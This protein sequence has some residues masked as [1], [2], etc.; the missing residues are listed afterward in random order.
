[1]SA[2]LP[3]SGN[4]HVLISWNPLAIGERNWHDSDDR[5]MCLLHLSPWWVVPIFLCGENSTLFQLKSC[6]RRWEDLSLLHASLTLFE[7]HFLVITRKEGGMPTHDASF[8]N[9]RES[10]LLSST[11]SLDWLDPN[12][13]WKNLW[14]WRLADFFPSKKTQSNPKIMHQE[15]W[16]RSRR[17]RNRGEAL[18]PPTACMQKPISSCIET[19]SESIEKAHALLSSRAASQAGRQPSRRTT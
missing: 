15:R 6:I 2:Y 18:T 17:S 16:R 8:N 9:A 13:T 14:C 19:H 4:L 12:A 10:Y 1:M 7:K 5:S 11:R 3:H